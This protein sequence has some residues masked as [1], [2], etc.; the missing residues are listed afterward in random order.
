MIASRAFGIAFRVDAKTIE[1][2][3][4]F[5]ID[6]EAASGESHFQLPVPS[7]FLVD[8]GGTVRFRYYNPDYKIRID[9][10]ALLS[11]AKEVSSEAG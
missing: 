8:T 5:G 1:R 6:L 4:G 10:Q 2:Y 7:V 11:A 9:P 3:R